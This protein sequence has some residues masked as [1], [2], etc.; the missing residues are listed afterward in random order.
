MQEALFYGFSLERHVPGGQLLRKIDRCGDLLSVRARLELYYSKVWRPL[1]ALELMIR[2]LIVD[3]CFGV[4]SERR[5]CEE[6]YHS[7]RRDDRAGRR[8]DCRRVVRF[9]FLVGQY[10][11][12]L[13]TIG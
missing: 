7:L 3:Y 1:I 6:I 10:F 11:P 8:H 13:G 4:R 9:F 12:F 5:L 2:T